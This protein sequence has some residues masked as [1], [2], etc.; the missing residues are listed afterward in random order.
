MSV[1]IDAHRIQKSVGVVHRTIV[2]KP[3]KG[4]DIE[5]ESDLAVIT[6]FVC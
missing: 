6:T 3:S 4:T 2:F 1:D 5:L